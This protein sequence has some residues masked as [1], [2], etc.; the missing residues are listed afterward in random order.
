MSSDFE[1]WED[2][3][4]FKWSWSCIDEW[5]RKIVTKQQKSNINSNIYI[6]RSLHNS[7]IL[8][9]TSHWEVVLVAKM[10]EYMWDESH[11]R[12]CW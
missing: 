5:K 9:E 2:K 6:N 7:Y 3:N 10:I 1:I 11:H 8:A 12:S 4:F